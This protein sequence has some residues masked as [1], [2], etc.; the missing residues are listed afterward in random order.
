MQSTL[1]ATTLYEGLSA[2]AGNLGEVPLG[3]M[4]LS[5]GSDAILVDGAKLILT[6]VWPIGVLVRVRLL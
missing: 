3:L 4:Q 6:S 2:V 5:L 1:Q